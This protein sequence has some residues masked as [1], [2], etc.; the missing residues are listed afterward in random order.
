[1]PPFVNETLANA[2]N[3]YM[4]VGNSLAPYAFSVCSQKHRSWKLLRFYPEV[5][6]Y[7]FKKLFTNQASTDY[8]ALILRYMQSAGMIPQDYAEDNIA[9]S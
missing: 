7:L 5:E 2:L 3:G 8:D 9:K 1:M 4:Y 6:N